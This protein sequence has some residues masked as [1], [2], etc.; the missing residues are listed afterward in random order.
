MLDHIICSGEHTYPSND[1][2]VCNRE[3]KCTNPYNCIV[4][5]TSCNTTCTVYSVHPMF[6]AREST[7]TIAC[8]NQHMCQLAHVTN[9]STIHFSVNIAAYTILSQLTPPKWLH[10]LYSREL[11][12]SNDFNTHLHPT[13]YHI[14]I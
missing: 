11:F 1:A 5:C 12:S 2:Y 10:V 6:L 14:M 9:T 7:V 4:N 8:V 3:S 13:Y